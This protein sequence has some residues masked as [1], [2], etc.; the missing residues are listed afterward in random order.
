MHDIHLPP[1]RSIIIQ[2]VGTAVVHHSTESQPIT[3][4]STQPCTVRRTTTR[5]ASMAS[6]VGQRSTPPLGRSKKREP[7]AS[8][9]ALLRG[10]RPLLL[11]LLLLMLL[12]RRTKRA[13]PTKPASTLR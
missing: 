1:T 6:I 13:R 4:H 5:C 9:A 3:Q 2:T 11:L 10:R 8:T 12:R 7:I